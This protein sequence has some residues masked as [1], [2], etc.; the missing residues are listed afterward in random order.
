[1]LGLTEMRMFGSKQLKVSKNAKIISVFVS[2]FCLFDEKPFDMIGYK[3]T[4]DE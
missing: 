2:T 3:L 1:M 4:G